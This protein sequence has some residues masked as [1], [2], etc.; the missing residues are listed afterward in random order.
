[1]KK[2]SQSGTTPARNMPRPR[3]D[4]AKGTSRN[5][6]KAPTKKSSERTTKKLAKEITDPNDTC[7][8]KMT[9]SSSDLSFHLLGIDFGTTKTMVAKY[10]QSKLHAIPQ[11]L[12]RGSFEMP[13]S[14]YNTMEGDV[15][16][17]DE[18]VDEGE[19]DHINHIRRF[20]M[21][22]GHPGLA[23]VGR[24][25]GTAEQLSAEFLTHVRLKLEKEVL[26]HDVERAVLTV[27]AMFG[28]A[29]RKSLRAAAE[30]AGF[31]HVELLEEP[32]AAGI[33]YCDQSEVTGALRILVVDWGGGTFDVALVER[34]DG[35]EARVIPEF[36][37]GLDDIGGEF[38]DDCL[39]RAASDSLIGAGYHALDQQE[40]SM[41]GRYRRDI[42]RAKERLSSQDEVRMSFLLDGGSP[43]TIVLKRGIL[44]QAIGDA[45]KR[46]AD[47]V[48]DLLQRCR[49]AGSQPDF[50]LL[51]GGTS[52]IPMVKRVFEE[53]LKIECRTW[54]QGREAIALGAALHA[55]ELWTTT[56]IV[57]VPS[58]Q[59]RKEDIKIQAMSVYRA[60]LEAAWL[61]GRI[62]EEEHKFLNG[63]R[64]DLELTKND[65]ESLEKQI[66]GGLLDQVATASNK[67][68]AEK[69]TEL[70]K[71]QPS[72][73][74]PL[75]LPPPQTRTSKLGTSH[76][77]YLQRGMDGFTIQSSLDDKIIQTCIVEADQG[78]A[79]AQALLG[80]C[81]GCGHR[82]PSNQNEAV[83]WIRLAAE[84]GHSLGQ[85]FLGC[86]YQIGS[87]VSKDHNSAAKWFLKAAQQGDAFAQF[88]IGKCYQKGLG[89]QQS[90][91]TAADFFRNAA[92]Q[93]NANAQYALAICYR[94]G[95]GVARNQSEYLHWIKVAAQQDHGSALIQKGLHETKE[96]FRDVGNQ[97]KSEWKKFWSK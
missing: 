8:T 76:E 65:V 37:G 64:R 69:E 18:A 17:G 2:K 26:H 83:K 67:Q 79:L 5:A 97:V 84:Q 20:K 34:P 46:G 51:A 14:I 78:I 63:K 19:S 22:L 85:Y 87:G 24:K 36:V 93:G 91:K 38:L 29:Q 32:V 7:G 70:R 86:R 92:V 30:T 1:M 80:F 54:S 49:G 50:I 95:K 77:K 48:G 42:T 81:Y 72:N 62:T 52:R 44:E 43:V 9:K 15:L 45:V 13:T 35:Q 96:G 16:F 58:I 39:W 66:L 41:W 71:Q 75:K 21:K 88:E 53:I 23:H 57:V 60:L 55:K 6:A 3:N 56:P 47:F 82:L 89:V 59:N 10:D 31:T 12:G 94:D 27:P 68:P 40:P 74:T 33:A 25:S 4:A 28:P 11:Q 61:D 73:A 90:D